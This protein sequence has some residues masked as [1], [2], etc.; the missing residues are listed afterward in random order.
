MFAFV[1]VTTAAAAA[2]GAIAST[3]T[4]TSAFPTF[5]AAAFSTALPTGFEEQRNSRRPHR[6]AALLLFFGGVEKT[7]PSGL[8]L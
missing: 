2:A 7:Q 8:T 3:F 5:A 4:L 6:N 1:I